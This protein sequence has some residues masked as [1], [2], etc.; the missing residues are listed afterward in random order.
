MNN[1]IIKHLKRI[2]MLRWT[3]IFLIIAIVAAIFRIYR[4]CSKRCGDC[5]N[6][7]FYFCGVISF[8][9]LYWAE[10]YRRKIN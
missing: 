5:Q 7:V 2:A 9:R 8:Y 10:E 4:H 1:G 6:F 3:V